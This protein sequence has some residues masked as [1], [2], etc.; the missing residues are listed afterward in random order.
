MFARLDADENGTLSAEEFAK[1][2]MGGKHGMR[3]GHGEGHGKHRGN[4]QKSE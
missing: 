4:K 3:H 2:K 1:A